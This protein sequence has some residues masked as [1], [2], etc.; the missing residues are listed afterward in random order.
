M[1][2]NKELNKFL[3]KAYNQ[4]FLDG[5]HSCYET[6]E[7][8]RIGYTKTDNYNLNIHYGID[9]AVK[10]LLDFYERYKVANPQNEV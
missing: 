3:E 1:T 9:L 2:E 8:I 10:T 6:L 4:A 5:V 7:D